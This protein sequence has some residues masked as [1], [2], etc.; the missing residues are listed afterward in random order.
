[1]RDAP[2]RWSQPANRL[3]NNTGMLHVHRLE[4]VRAST[5]CIQG[6][7]PEAPDAPMDGRCIALG[8]AGGAAVPWGRGIMKDVYL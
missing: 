2:T 5:G 8:C 7:R 6:A 4:D 3:V 1:M